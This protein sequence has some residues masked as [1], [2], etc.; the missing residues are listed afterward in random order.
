MIEHYA[1]ETNHQMHAEIAIVGGGLGGLISAIKLA[2]AG[3]SVK[4]FEKKEYPFHKVC[5]EY[6]SNEVLEFLIKLGF[7]PHLHGASTITKLRISSP[8]G[9]N[10]YSNLDSGGFGISRY[11]MDAELVKLARQNGVEVFEKT[12]I[13]S[14]EKQD[15]GFK[16]K[17][18]EGIE[19]S[20]NLV[21]GSW[22]KRDALDK[23]LERDF[24]DKKTGFLGVKYHIKT[25]YPIDEVGLD[26]FEN[27]YCGIVKI[28]S[29]LYNLCY[30]YK[31]DKE[32][33]FTNLTELNTEIL[34]KNPV[35]KGIFQNSDFM[36]KQPEVINQISFANK[37]SVI[38]NILLCGD[39]A[40]LI[41]PLCGNGM[42]MAI[43]GANLL[44]ESIIAI[45]K[46]NNFPLNKKQ[47]VELFR[48]YQQNWNKFFSTRLFWGR[49]IQSVFGNPF[50]TNSVLNGV[51]KIPALQKWLVAQT[52]GKPII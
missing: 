52:H 38:N 32:K 37:Q 12:K 14:I 48:T 40:G 25:D 50:I 15:G 22:G 51:H 33:S 17:T 45:A 11:C 3:F 29:D 34:F 46:P 43:S 27:G 39:S 20:A 23:K 21:I 7:N 13:L 28:E 8:S 9:K 42:A 18:S 10:F 49:K 1:K 5:G 4:L 2:K 31:K 30:L 36:H 16:L 47:Q 41:T 35:I 24:I 6:V 26:N 19:I 44:A